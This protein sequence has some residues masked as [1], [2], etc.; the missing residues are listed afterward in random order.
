MWT[1]LSVFSVSS[2]LSVPVDLV[3][4]WLLPGYY[5]LVACLLPVFLLNSWCPE[6]L[7]QPEVT[8]YS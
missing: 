5:L 8:E 7:G 2:L 6:L 1:D 3:V 4:T